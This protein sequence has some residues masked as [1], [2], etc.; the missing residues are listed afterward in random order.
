M[1]LELGVLLH[2]GFEIRGLLFELCRDLVSGLWVP[3]V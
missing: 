3:G 2:A 1:N